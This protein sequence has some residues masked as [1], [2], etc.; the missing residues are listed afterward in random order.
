MF[1]E[2]IIS[3]SVNLFRIEINIINNDENLFGINT[4]IYVVLNKFKCTESI[5]Y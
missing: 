2:T 5:F 3:I 1:I 4:G